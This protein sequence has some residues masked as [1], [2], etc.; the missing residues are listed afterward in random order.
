M[1]GCG[2]FVYGSAS[3]LRRIRM[4]RTDNEDEDEGEER[5]EGKSD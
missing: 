5:E 3:N 4:N 1:E 2:L